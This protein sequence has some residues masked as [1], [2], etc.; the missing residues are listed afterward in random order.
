MLA[1]AVAPSAEATPGFRYGVAAGEMTATSALLWTR[2]NELGPVR[3]HVWPAPRKGMPPVQ[4]TLSPTNARD[5][6]VQ[7]RV[8]GLK[9][10]TRYTY[11]FSTPYRETEIA[12]GGSF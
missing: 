8:H 4:I 10:N 1:L 3:L 11:L 2:S 9:P 5:R 12:A 6:V 7:R